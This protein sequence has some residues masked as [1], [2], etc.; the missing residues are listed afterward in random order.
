ML[1]QVQHDESENSLPRRLT[2]VTIG[3][4]LFDLDRHMVDIKPVMEHLPQ[5][6]Q[7]AIA[8]GAIG[9]DEVG[10]QHCFRRGALMSFEQKETRGC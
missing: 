4:P 6:A 2:P 9:H 7:K 3:I 10:G 8:R 5:R 1:K